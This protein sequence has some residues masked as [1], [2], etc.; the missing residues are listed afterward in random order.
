MTD[1]MAEQT[2]LDPIGT[3]VGL[4]TAVEP[5]LAT[6]LVEDIVTGVAGG[7]AKRR[8]LAQALVEQP[9]VLRDGRSP[10]PRA[11]GDLL[12]ALRRAGAQVVS[13]PCCAQC[14]K[15]LRTLQRRGE[16]WYCAVCAA[17]PEPCSACGE[18]RVITTRDRQGR[19]RCPRCPDPDDRDPL[20]ILTGVIHGLDPS[21][22]AQ[23]I[24]SAASRVFCRPNQLRRLAWAVEDTPGLLTG[25]GAQA[26]IPGVLR[27]IDHLCEAG[28]QKITR[29]SCP[30]CHRVIPLARRQGGQWV[31]RNCVAKAR[32]VPCSRCGSVREPATRDA[33]GKPLCPNCLVNDPA[34]REE[35]SACGRRSRV[36]T[37]T[38]DGPLCGACRPWKTMNCAICGR[39]VP[40]V[41]STATGQPWCGACQKRWAPCSV[42]GHVQAIRGGTMDAPLCATCLSSDSAPWPPCRSCGGIERL[43]SSGSCTRCALDQRLRRLL[44]DGTGRVRPELALLH[45]TLAAADRPHTVLGWLSKNTASAVLADLATSERQLTHQALDEIPPSKPV[46]HLRSVL[47]ATGALPARD[48]HLAR[49]ER[50]ISATLN[51]RADRDDKEPL[52]RFT[53]WH[54]LRRLRQRNNGTDATHSQIV[55][56]RQRVRAA[57]VLLDWLHARGLTLATC[58]QADLD[59]WLTSPNATHLTEAGHFVRWA[60]ARR[61]TRELQYPAVK[62]HGPTRPLDHD[63]RWKQTKR[64]LHD[65]A[66]TPEDRVAGLLLLLYAQWPSTIS[67]LTIDHVNT[68]GDQ[69][70]LSL[71]RTPITL[72]EP[73]ASLTLTLVATRRGHAVLGE[74]GT[75]PWLFPGGQPGRPISPD[76]LGQRLRRLGIRLADTR[77][78]A[79]FQLSTELPAALLARTLGIHIDVAVQ[80]QRAS[81]GDWTNYAADVS[82]RPA[83]QD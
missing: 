40:C 38:A 55:V 70:R 7:R 73:L 43:R 8:R 22:P 66:L 2:L 6:D 4:V 60:R 81:S 62:W 63:E 44:D 30:G 42:C 29:P 18:N 47:V 11:I 61:I 67:R 37:R 24:A 27:L 39:T 16:E 17:R 28:A 32:A 19:P 76:G 10:A 25:D 21:L 45:Q 54:L 20:S 78:T 59:T 80:W 13:P 69:V 72:P 58:R 82:R 9:M 48:E 68:A 34:N 74:R 57:I 83:R 51:E 75:S 26:P 71:G 1:E 36:A 35:C 41:I 49:L 23:A 56:V 5:A 3:I 64:L 53:V 65:D 33:D 14:G 15:H 46:E 52:R 79:L 12:I 31:C 50:W 77:S